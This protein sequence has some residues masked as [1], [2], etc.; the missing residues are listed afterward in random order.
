MKRPATYCRGAE[1]SPFQAPSELRAQALLTC[2]CACAAQRELLSADLDAIFDITNRLRLPIA[3]RISRA[4]TVRI[5]AAPSRERQTRQAKLGVPAHEPSPARA[6]ALRQWCCCGADRWLKCGRVA[7][8]HFPRNPPLPVQAR[9]NPPEPARPLRAWNF[10]NGR[11][12]RRLKFSYGE[13]NDHERTEQVHAI[14]TTA[15]WP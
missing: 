2:R 7:I 12:S 4:A 11:S 3:S 1:S 10:D 5:S 14:S 8:S 6:L 13:L 15:S 9:G